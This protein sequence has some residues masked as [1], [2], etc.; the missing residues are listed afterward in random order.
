M[1]G[2]APPGGGKNLWLVDAVAP[3]GGRD[4]VLA[5]LKKDVF[6]DRKV[7][8]LQPAPGDGLGVVEW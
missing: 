2:N 8:S 7:K 1:S 6:G 4:E 3:F 5:T